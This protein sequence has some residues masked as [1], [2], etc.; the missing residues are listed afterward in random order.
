M[1]AIVSDYSIVIKWMLLFH[2][3]VAVTAIISDD[4]S[5]SCLSDLLFTLSWLNKSFS[6][7]RLSLIFGSSRLLS[8]VVWHLKCFMEISHGLTTWFTIYS[9][10]MNWIMDSYGAPSICN[11][12]WIS[13]WLDVGIW[14]EINV[15]TSYV[16]ELNCWTE[17]PRY[18]AIILY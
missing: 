17:Y 15:L 13:I 18:P 8:L 3:I 6:H 5:H 1:D 10:D 4:V 9:N 14:L 7:G 2:I 11:E 12:L 16:W